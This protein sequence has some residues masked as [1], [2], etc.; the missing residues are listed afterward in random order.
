MTEERDNYRPPKCSGFQHFWEY[1]K[2]HCIIICFLA[3]A[4]VFMIKDFS[5]R[6]KADMSI[7]VI[8]AFT[9]DNKICEEQ[10]KIFKE[11]LAKDPAFKGF[12]LGYSF[13]LL[14]ETVDGQKTYQDTVYL[15]RLIVE[16]SE[17]KNCIFIVDENAK[18]VLETYQ[19]DYLSMICE[20]PEQY[21]A[22]GIMHK[23]MIGLKAPEQS[24]CDE[25]AYKE[26]KQC[27]LALCDCFHTEQ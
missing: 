7:T 21:T 16:I 5:G 9:Y 23:L 2:W 3:I 24:R 27:Y 19:N 22:S 20:I 14:P 10:M 17:G 26:E 1:Y 13:I 11:L 15:S 6:K 18:E 4:A 8:S 12:S 25:A